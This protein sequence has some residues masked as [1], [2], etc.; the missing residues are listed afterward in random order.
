MDCAAVSV[1]ESPSAFRS[2][3]VVSAC[4]WTNTSLA[5]V[6]GMLSASYFGT[7]LEKDC[8]LVAQTI[9]TLIGTFLL[10]GLYGNLLVSLAEVGRREGVAGQKRFA[11]RTLRQLTLWLAPCI[12]VVFAG[13]RFLT[14]AVA[15][16]FTADRADLSASL[17]RISIF[18]LA[19]V[20][21]SP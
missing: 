9:P 8:Y 17:L 1:S 12:L 11:H 7:S 16:G 21:T 10:G 14:A 5:L 15:P 6:L 20:A 4:R 3:L 2:A 18:G 13:A 19:G